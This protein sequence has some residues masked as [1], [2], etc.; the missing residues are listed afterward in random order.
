MLQIAFVHYKTCYKTE[1]KVATKLE[2]LNKACEIVI[3]IWKYP[4]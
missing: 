4:L 2:V 3:Q 1:W